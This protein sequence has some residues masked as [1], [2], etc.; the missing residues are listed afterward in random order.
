MSIKEQDERGKL[1]KV[2]SN[3]IAGVAKNPGVWLPVCPEKS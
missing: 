2:A 3:T 1:E